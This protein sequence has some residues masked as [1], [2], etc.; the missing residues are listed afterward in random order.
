[1]RRYSA[2]NLAKC[3]LIRRRTLEDTKKRGTMPKELPVTVN[4][5]LSKK[6]HILGM[7]PPVAKEK[8]EKKS[9]QR[10]VTMQKIIK[11]KQD[12][13]ARF[14]VVEQVDPTH[15]KVYESPDLP[16][17]GKYVLLIKQQ[18]S[19]V[20]FP[21]TQKLGFKMTYSGN[22]KASLLKEEEVDQA[23]K[24]TYDLM[25]N[26]KIKVKVPKKGAEDAATKENG[27]AGKVSKIKDEDDDS[28]SGKVVLIQIP[29][30]T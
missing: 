4:K 28:K 26:K 5:E 20:L 8:Q 14:K 12:G 29:S 13:P 15:V 23:I 25:K 19:I 30:R 6:E 10:K 22:P 27:A 17:D 11:Q 24:N 2:A 18:D 1:M 3:S 21:L 9:K 16:Q 7:F